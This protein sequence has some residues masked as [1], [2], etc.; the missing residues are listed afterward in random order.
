VKNNEQKATLNSVDLWAV[1]GII[2][3]KYLATYNVYREEEGN[4]AFTARITS[5]GI[6]CN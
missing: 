2:C 4:D 1:I 5:H 6:W 3:T